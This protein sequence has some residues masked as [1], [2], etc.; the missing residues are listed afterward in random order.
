MGNELLLING[1]F[2]VDGDRPIESVAIA[3]G[4]IVAT[5]SAAEAR[6]RL[7]SRAETIDLGGAFVTPGLSDAHAHVLNYG[8]SRMGVPCWPSDVDSVTDIVRRIAEADASL[9]PGKW[10]RGRGYDPGKLAEGR[11][12]TA[13][14][15]N[16]P[17]G[18][19]VVLDSFDFHRRVANHAAIAAA[20]ISV[21]QR[22]PIGGRIVRDEGG[23]LT[24]EFL[25]AARG[26]LD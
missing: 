26:L 18:R 10:I 8:R 13:S 23:D 24:G 19:P 9:E 16:L 15:L 6:D 4:R 12:P 17:S 14:E 25:D 3:G 22:D 2:F 11:A 20:D 21:G 7:S 5:G 1:R